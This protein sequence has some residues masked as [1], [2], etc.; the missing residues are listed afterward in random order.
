M[1]IMNE[2]GALSHAL[3]TIQVRDAAHFQPYIHWPRV[4]PWTVETINVEPLS[5]LNEGLHTHRPALPL[6]K[7][8]T[9]CWLLWLLLVLSGSADCC[10]L[11]LLLLLLLL[12]L[13]LLWLARRRLNLYTS[14]ILKRMRPR[15]ISSHF[16]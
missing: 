8:M 12:W 13:R 9:C 4:H 11:L 15:S 5:K 14:K 1:F 16:P 10:W 7:L 3:N 2:P 6:Y